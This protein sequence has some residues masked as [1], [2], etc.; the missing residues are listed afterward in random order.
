MRINS[1]TGTQ[2][3]LFLNRAENGKQALNIL[4]NETIDL[5]LS[6]VIMPE[7]DGYQLA[8]IVKVKYPTTKIQMA[9]GYTGAAEPSMIVANNNNLLVKPFDSQTLLQ[10]LRVLL[11]S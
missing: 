8:A 4:A 3:T 11:S 7:M 10:R 9:S 6:D 5:M 2:N 1:P